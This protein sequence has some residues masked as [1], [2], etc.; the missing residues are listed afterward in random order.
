VKELQAQGYENVSADL[1]TRGDVKK[2][3]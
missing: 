1:L 3:T 2:K